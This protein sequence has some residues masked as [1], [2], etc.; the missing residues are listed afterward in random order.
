MEEE[1]ELLDEGHKVILNLLQRSGSESLPRSQKPQKS[2]AL[3]NNAQALDS[4]VCNPRVI[5]LTGLAEFFPIIPLH[6]SGLHLTTVA[7]EK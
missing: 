2:R 6:W 7:I 1:D 5:S 4:K 3:Q